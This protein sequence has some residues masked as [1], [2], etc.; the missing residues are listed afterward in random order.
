MISI[1][2]SDFFQYVDCVIVI[3]KLKL[4]GYAITNCVYISVFSSLL[5]INAEFDINAAL[6][7]SST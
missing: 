3:L 2:N 5:N 1:I 7:V 4:I 6:I